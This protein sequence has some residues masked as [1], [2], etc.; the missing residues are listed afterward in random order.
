[1][2][3]TVIVI[4]LLK[5]SLAGQS[6]ADTVL[7]GKL[8]LNLKNAQPTK[9]YRYPLDRDRA[10]LL[11]FDKG[12]VVNYK[13]ELKS[14]DNL[15]I[16]TLRFTDGFHIVLKN[17][18][19]KRMYNE[20]MI[21]KKN[22]LYLMIWGLSPVNH[23]SLYGSS[24]SY[25]SN[26]KLASIRE[27]DEIDKITRNRHYERDG[28]FG[29]EET[30]DSLGKYITMVVYN[31]KGEIDF[32]MQRKDSAI[33]REQ[34]GGKGWL[35]QIDS[36][37]YNNVH[38]GNLVVYYPNKTIKARIPY[39]KDKVTGIVYHYYPD[40]KL[41]KTENFIENKKTGAYILYNQD[42]S[43]KKKGVN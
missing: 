5:L 22:K 25:Y 1:M 31:S 7:E 17:K 29:S 35:Q 23:S 28:R 26:K 37:D 42:G 21:D 36:L 40:G 4:C 38:E 16:D 13:F 11:K 19:G 12:L 10:T 24:Y 3:F 30:R 8:L 41:E 33:V 39:K 34:W 14:T 27:Y 20:I 18:E 9:Y 2:K 6:Q 32:K 15:K 43:I